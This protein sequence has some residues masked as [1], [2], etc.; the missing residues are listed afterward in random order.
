M[1]NTVT[2]LIASIMIIAFGSCKRTY[3]CECT[4]GFSGNYKTTERIKAKDREDANAECTKDNPPPLT[5]DGVY[6]ELK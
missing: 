3:I 6:C 5:P 1:K 2:L 4:G